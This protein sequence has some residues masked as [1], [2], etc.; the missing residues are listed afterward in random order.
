MLSTS[1]KSCQSPIITTTASPALS[2]DAR[3]RAEGLVMIEET[4][5]SPMKNDNVLQDLL[6]FAIKTMPEQDAKKQ[7]SLKTEGGSYLS[8]AELTIPL[9]PLYP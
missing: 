8:P 6:L 4:E 5:T 3:M 1:T 2:L 7:Y 9:D